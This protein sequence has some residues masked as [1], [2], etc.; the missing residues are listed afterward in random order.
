MRLINVLPALAGI[1][2]ASPEAQLIDVENL[3]AP[4]LVTP[5]QGVVSQVVSY[6]APS[7]QALA[8]SA[9]VTASLT[10][11]AIAKRSVE[12]RAAHDPECMGLPTGMCN[13]YSGKKKRTE[14]VAKRDAT[15]AKQTV[16][17]GPVASPDT[18]AAFA[19]STVLSVS[20]I[21]FL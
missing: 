4:S 10:P 18:A 5:L 17:P 13:V 16:G 2:F 6:A 11:S 15:C 20:F 1:A 7:V 14:Q 12:K 3:A 19:N 21:L 9:A 8:A